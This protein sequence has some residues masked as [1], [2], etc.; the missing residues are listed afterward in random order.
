MK[1]IVA[2]ASGFIGSAAVREAIKDESITQI[3]VLS[4]GTPLPDDIA[5]HAKVTVI[6]TSFA[7]YS[8]EVLN[9]LVDAE[10]CIWAIGGR[11]PDFHDLLVAH[12]TCVEYP[13]IAARAF[14][15]TLSPLL[16]RGKMFRFVFVSGLLQI[17]HHDHFRLY[18]DAEEGLRR[19]RLH[20]STRLE[21]RV[22]RPHKVTLRCYR[23]FAS[24]LSRVFRTIPINVL[25]RSLIK[26][27]NNNYYNRW[28]KTN[29]EAESLVRL[30]GAPDINREG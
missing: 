9:Q 1:I 16:P 30:A 20:Y 21:L 12:R 24:L 11:V 15:A 8:M 19:I 4:R 13:A 6:R 22:A 5:N 18:S 23:F 2:G 10:A 28:L 26:M 3:C 17:R 7:E 25:A 27:A 14:A 29:F